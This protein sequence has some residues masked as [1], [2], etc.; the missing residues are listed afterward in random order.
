MKKGSEMW[1]GQFIQ[2]GTIPLRVNLHHPDELYSNFDR[3]GQVLSDSMLSY[4]DKN[5]KV[6]PFGIDIEILFFCPGIT[7]TKKDAVINLFKTIYR[8]LYTQSRRRLLL[9][10]M[11]TACLILIC[12]IFFITGLSCFFNSPLASLYILLGS[13]TAVACAVMLY[14]SRNLYV[15]MKNAHR[16]YKSN[17]V[18]K[19]DPLGA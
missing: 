13:A 9:L 15:A 14:L 12:L 2:N 6:I 3:T 10:A 7:A 18:F 4:I 8:D 17:I 16:T 19:S 5:I 11:C 1:R